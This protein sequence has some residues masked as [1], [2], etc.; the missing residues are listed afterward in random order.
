[1]DDFLKADIFFLISAFGVIVVTIVLAVALYYLV[2]ILR[3]VRH[4]SKVAKEETDHIAEDVESFRSALG[5]AKHKRK[6]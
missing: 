1:M 4:I 3:D 2:R 5:D 6:R